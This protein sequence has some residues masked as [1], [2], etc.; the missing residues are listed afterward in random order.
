MQSFLQALPL[1]PGQLLEPAGDGGALRKACPD[2][3]GAVSRA[4]PSHLSIELALQRII[5]VGPE[6]LCRRSLQFRLKKYQ[7]PEVLWH[8]W[9]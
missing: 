3:S 9:A 4:L 8:L 7:P 1:L 5:E 2:S 6:K